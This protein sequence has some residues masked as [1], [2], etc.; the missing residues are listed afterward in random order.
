MLTPKIPP[1]TYS[2][3]SEAPSE[4]GSERYEPV[5]RKPVPNIHVGQHPAHIAYQER[6]RQPTFPP[7]DKQD[8]ERK[9][10]DRKPPAN[11][12]DP[13][14]YPSRTSSR[15]AQADVSGRTTPTASKALSVDTEVGEK[16]KRE[17]FKLGEVPSERKKSLPSP[18]N[19]PSDEKSM[20]VGSGRPGPSSA[21]QRPTLPDSVRPS[22]ATSRHTEQ[23]P[24]DNHGRYHSHSASATTPLGS[25]SMDLSSDSPQRKEGMRREKTPTVESRQSYSK[26]ATTPRATGPNAQSHRT[27]NSES[28]S[29]SEGSPLLPL[30]IRTPMG[31]F[32][33]DEDIARMLGQDFAVPPLSRKVS[34][35]GRHGRSYSDIAIAGTI[36]TPPPYLEI[37]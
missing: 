25:Q 12:T 26:Q 1:R 36:T 20:Q 2:N 28:F 3:I 31:D 17:G 15:T 7:I 19:T 24:D 30:P 8:T 5:G 22:T 10:L 11:S 29:V 35:A 21:P 6:G 4:L 18:L 16:Q 37:F 34:M 32:S 23:S 13:S 27:T 33:M 14:P 9:S